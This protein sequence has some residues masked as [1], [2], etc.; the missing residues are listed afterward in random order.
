MP[1]EIDNEVVLPLRVL[2]QPDPCVSPGGDCGACVLGA[3][4]G[5]KIEEVYSLFKQKVEAFS[6]PCLAD[7]L[8]TARAYGLIDRLVVNVP[9]WAPIS[10]S[11]WYGAAAWDFAIEWFSYIRM[12]LDAG[13]YG[14]AS[15]D[16]KRSGPLSHPDHAILIAGAREIAIP[17]QDAEGKV[18]A[19]RIDQEILI[20]NSSKSSPPEE[21]VEV[22]TFLTKW[23]G[24]NAY[25]AR[26]GNGIKA[27]MSLAS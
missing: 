17:I 24:Y 14:I 3:I 18:T 25:L 5:K 15:V 27:E 23:G 4:T 11:A 1:V 2:K 26:P 20:S 10:S 22:K 16:S 7:A 8:Y 9:F 6:H 21:W 12:G 19:H 13:Y